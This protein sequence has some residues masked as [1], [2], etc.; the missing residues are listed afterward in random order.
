VGLAFAL[1]FA[2]AATVTGTT[3]GA[4]GGADAGALPRAAG[5][6]GWMPQDTGSMAP[7]T[8]AR[9][10]AGADA[11]ADVSVDAGAVASTEADAGDAGAPGADADAARPPTRSGPAGPVRVENRVDA[12]TLAALRQTQSRARE[13]GLRPG[14]VPAFDGALGR[15]QLAVRDRNRA[16][17]ASAVAEARRVLDG[18][19]VDRAFVS[20]KLARFNR[21]FDGKAA[22]KTEPLK[23][24]TKEVLGRIGRKDWIGANELLNEGFSRLEQGR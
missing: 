7:Q 4:D 6:A 12:G 11:V 15:A 8:G 2:P 14:D 22:A 9:S 3:A 19:V 10:D 17:A 5:D 13:R 23:P 18:V 20:A 21:A 24:L 1:S 16:G